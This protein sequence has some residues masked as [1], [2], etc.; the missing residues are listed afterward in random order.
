[1][2]SKR[3]AFSHIQNQTNP[4]SP[5]A[6]S[7]PAPRNLIKKSNSLKLSDFNDDGFS[8]IKEASKLRTSNSFD[9][10][11]NAPISEEIEEELSFIASTS[12]KKSAIKIFRDSSCD[13]NDIEIQCD[14]ENDLIQ[15]LVDNEFTE[16]ELLIKEKNPETFLRLIAEKLRAELFDH[17]QE[18]MEVSVPTNVATPFNVYELLLVQMSRSQC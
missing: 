8:K 1:M 13:K 5:T 15:N 2:S 6:S 12:F 10:S 3:T 14:I 18:N 11:L 4:K 9:L 7:T 16:D 17:L